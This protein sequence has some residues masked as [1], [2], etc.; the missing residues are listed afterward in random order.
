[1]YAHAPTDTPVA[2]C[3]VKHDAIT[4]CRGFTAQCSCEASSRCIGHRRST[5]RSLGQ[6]VHCLVDTV[7]DLQSVADSSI[8]T[9]Q[10]LLVTPNPRSQ[11]PVAAIPTRELRR[12]LP[13]KT[14]ERRKLGRLKPRSGKQSNSQRS[15]QCSIPPAS[16]RLNA[17]NLYEVCLRCSTV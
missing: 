2:S 9:A 14:L 8:C 4:S 13:R 10:T 11:Q 17:A 3:C 6:D 5:E 15:R 16:I 12:T 7:Q 1:M